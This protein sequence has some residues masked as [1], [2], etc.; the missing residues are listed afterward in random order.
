MV[1]GG[2]VGRAFCLSHIDFKLHFLMLYEYART[3]TPPN[4]ISPC[5]KTHIQSITI[6]YLI[7][8]VCVGHKNSMGAVVLS[9][10][11]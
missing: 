9:G 5:G 1:V 10:E 4:L 7:F 3:L 8:F 6:I 2:G 11:T